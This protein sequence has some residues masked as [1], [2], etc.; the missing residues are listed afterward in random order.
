[1][2]TV[3][4]LASEASGCCAGMS[5]EANQIG[6]ATAVENIENFARVASTPVVAGPRG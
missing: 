6:L 2:T 5:P 1:M 3:P 4:R